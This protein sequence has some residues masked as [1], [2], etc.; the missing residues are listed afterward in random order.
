VKSARDAAL[1]LALVAILAAPGPLRSQS[2]AVDSG[3]CRAFVQ[4]FY[5][6]YVPITNSRNDRFT[7]MLRP[8]RSSFDP[9]LWRMLVADDEAQSR[10]TEIVGLDFD[11]IVNSQDPSP[12]FK[13]VSVSTTGNQCRAHVDG[14]NDG[15]REERVTPELVYSDGRWVFLNFHYRFEINGKWRDGDLIQILKELR[16]SRAAAAQEKTP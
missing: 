5:D 13:V 12:E 3:S 8:R 1:L 16:K 9:K 11:P 7:V 15:V 4:N 6:W 14:F 2:P 10:A